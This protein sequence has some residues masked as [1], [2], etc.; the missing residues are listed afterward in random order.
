MRREIRWAAVAVVALLIGATCAELYARLMAPYYTAVARMLTIGR[1][2]EI[3]AMEVTPSDVG[4][5]TILRLVGDVR[6]NSTD[7]SPAGR[8][9]TR[10]Q[11]GSVVQTPIIFWAILFLWPAATRRQRVAYCLV[12]LPIFLAV[13]AVTTAVQ[14]MHNLPEASA[15]L[16][17]EVDPLTLWERWAQFLEN[18][19]H[20]AV[21]VCGVLCAIFIAQK[22]YPRRRPALMAA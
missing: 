17:G 18:G 8:V 21:D 20:V 14:L 2:W 5:G 13:E 1:P 19:G 3:V 9:V 10:V 15:L 4:P 16:A 12:G 6:R 7:V 11:V 22:V